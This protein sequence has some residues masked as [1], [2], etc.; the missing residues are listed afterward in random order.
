MTKLR[1]LHC[2]HINKNGNHNCVHNGHFPH[3]KANVNRGIKDVPEDAMH[4]TTKLLEGH[5]PT[6]IA[7]QFLEI[8]GGG[9]LPQ[10]S[11]AKLRDAVLMRKYN[12]NATETTA[13]TLIRMLIEDETMSFICHAGSYDEAKKLVRVRR[14]RQSKGKNMTIEEK[15]TSPKSIKDS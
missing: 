8:S 11:I 14:K 15:I 12:S 2:F 10:K 5:C 13:E 9:K 7:Q 4:M 3:T 6:S 1:S